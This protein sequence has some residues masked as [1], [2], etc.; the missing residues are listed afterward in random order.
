MAVV[1]LEE[2]RIEASRELEPLVVM[3]GGASTL[4]PHP[5]MILSFL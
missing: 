4:L 3:T 2:V 1:A 5:P